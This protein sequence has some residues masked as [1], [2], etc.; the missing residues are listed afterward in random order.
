MDESSDW[1]QQVVATLSKR[2]HWALDI[3]VL[4]AASMDW[5]VLVQR[6]ELTFYKDADGIPASVNVFVGIEYVERKEPSLLP[7]VIEYPLG[8]YYDEG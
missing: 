4:Q 1:A 7:R 3:A 2:V 5:D 6:G 8:H